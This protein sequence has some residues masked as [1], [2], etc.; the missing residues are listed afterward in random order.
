K[1][2][3]KVVLLVIPKSELSMPGSF[4]SK[5][6][7]SV[8]R[9]ITADL[10]APQYEILRQGMKVFSDSQMAL[11]GGDTEWVLTRQ[12]VLTNHRVAR[13]ESREDPVYK[14][15]ILQCSSLDQL[16][17]SVPDAV[18]E[19]LAEADIVILYWAGTEQ[20]QG[21]LTTNGGATEM[22]FKLGD[23]NF[24]RMLLIATGD[25]VH[26]RNAPLWFHHEFFHIL[27][28]AYPECGFPRGN[29][30]YQKRELWPKD[31]TGSTE[32]DYYRETYT[33]WLLP[34]DN[35]LRMEWRKRNASFWETFLKAR[36]GK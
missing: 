16:E 15:F 22:S 21:I 25:E 11:T 7:V 19:E 3:R 9:E 13:G 27:E 29:H 31:Y 8:S 18:L 34:T 35:L 1:N 5:N 32:F 2:R 36:G 28:W 6:K 12:I 23:R 33:K 24:V 10:N 20:F 26:V 4:G 30:P 14:R 17:P